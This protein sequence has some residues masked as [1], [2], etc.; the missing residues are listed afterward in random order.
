[1]LPAGKIALKFDI[2]SNGPD[3]NKDKWDKVIQD[4]TAS[5]PQVGL[6]K[7]KTLFETADEAA[8]KSD[9]F[10]L[11]TN[12][13][14]MMTG[15]TLLNLDPFLNADPSFDKND[16]VGNV[17]ASV[18]RDNKTYALPITI[19]P[20]ILKYD[21]AKF[22]AANL[23]EPSNDWTVESFAD[24]LKALKPTSEGHGPFVDAD[25][26]GTYL[27]LLV[28]DY[29]GLPVDY[30]TNPPTINFTD[31]ATVTAIQ[32]ALDL[33]KNG[34]IG[35][36]ALGSLTSNF[37]NSPDNTTA[38]YPVS[39]NG[40]PGRKIAPGTT[41]DKPVLFP[42]GHQFTGLAYTLGTAYISTQTQNP[43]ACYRFISTIAK[44]PELF[45][46]MPARRSLLNSQ[47]LKASTSPEVLALYNQ[48]D[49]LL[50]DSHTIAFPTFDKGT[51]SVSN[52][53]LEHWLFEAF[54]VYVLNGADLTS[55]LKDAEGYAKTYQGCTATLPPESLLAANDQI[56]DTT[57]AYVA[58]AEK[59]DSR[60]K[61]I[62]DPIVNH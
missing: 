41:P 49:T 58:C 56:T 15:N 28:A 8:A 12:A 31:P 33:A 26:N 57:K 61:P 43:E 23:P 3:A 16:L 47:E 17:L 54:D 18:Q 44:H 34:Y 5:D 21:S 6:V 40:F 30:R 39:L 29:G 1:V 50:K 25:S 32:Q 62:L 11:S 27:L 35:Y 37:Q 38:I 46:S 22:S 19:E 59:A 52:F 9:C 42:M 53:L 51:V 14:P 4:F 36:N 48:V 10:Y 13:V 60:L 55:A 2:V 7:M 20:L 24:A 45:P